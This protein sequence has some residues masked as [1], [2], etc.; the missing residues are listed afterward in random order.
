VA[1]YPLSGPPLPRVPSAPASLIKGTSGGGFPAMM[2]R[3]PPLPQPAQPQS[4][5]PQLGQTAGVAGSPLGPGSP[6]LP[7]SPGMGMPGMG[8]TPNLGGG[9]GGPGS[10]GSASDLTGGIPGGL[11]LPGAVAGP[12]VSGVAPPGAPDPRGNPWA[13]PPVVSGPDDTHGGD[14]GGAGTQI[15]STIG[16]DGTPVPQFAPPP[17]SV[18]AGG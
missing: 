18:R 4:A 8:N 2:T 14:T 6:F 17:Q 7:G 3:G 10:T 15:G 16:A 12:P 5:Q 11:P 13:Y 9:W 1:Y